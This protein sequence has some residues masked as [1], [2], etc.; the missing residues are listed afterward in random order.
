MHTVE[1]YDRAKEFAAELGYHVREENLGGSGGGACTV[2]GRKCVFV[3]MTM[4]AAEQLEQ[5]VRALDA[6]P[7]SAVA[8]RPSELV[9]IWP[10]RRMAA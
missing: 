4:T 10:Q 8:D 9:A 6:D 3:D 5:I 2:A 1:L 7:Q